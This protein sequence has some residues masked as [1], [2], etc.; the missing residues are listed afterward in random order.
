[1]L[2][3]YPKACDLL[4]FLAFLSPDDLFFELFRT[5]NDYITTAHTRWILA[6]TSSASVQEVL[7][8][9]L[10]ILRLYSLLLCRGEQ[11]SYSMHKLV[12]AWSFERSD[13]TSR[14]KF[15]KIALEFLR[16]SGVIV[17]QEPERAAR[18]VPHIMAC[19]ARAREVYA[20]IDMDKVGIV[21]GLK[22]LADFLSISG[23]SNWG[24][25]LYSFV[26]G[27]YRR[28]RCADEYQY[29]ASAADLGD[30]MRSGGRCEEAVELLRPAL[31]EYREVHGPDDRSV[32]ALS[33]ARTLGCAL[34]K[35]GKVTEAEPLLRQVLDEYETFEG[36]LTTMRFLA[37]LL[38]RTNRFKEAE[39][40]SELAFDGLKELSGPTAHDT[41]YA[42]LDYAKV[43]QVSGQ[44]EKSNALTRHALCD[45]K[46]TF[47]PHNFYTMAC[48]AQT[49]ATSRL[50]GDFNRANALL[51][52]ALFGLE[53]TVG[54]GS[55]YTLS[56]VLELARCLRAQ[57]FYSDALALFERASDGYA[58]ALDSD[59]LEYLHSSSEEAGLRSFLQ[60]RAALCEVLEQASTRFDEFL[61]R[62]QHLRRSF[63]A[64]G[65]ALTYPGGS[66]GISRQEND[67]G[68]QE[69]SDGS[70]ESDLKTTSGSVKNLTMDTIG[71][72]PV[73]RRR[74]I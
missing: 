57:A 64:R 5:D 38:T 7:D 26:H 1:M 14:A 48:M 67:L 22:R 20:E 13:I 29:Y 6:G 41:L 52:E 31:A 55:P 45:Y 46:D 66:S 74:S 10:A 34:E 11:S 73:V 54:T 2:D 17:K 59:P 28:T 16:V 4:M 51:E 18:L 35:L 44:Y 25:E 63:S 30:I 37:L 61:R 72:V 60:R 32:V 65:R 58:A 19:F 53:R 40:L 8:S 71:R 49:G 9:S 62:G 50:L 39:E 42:L 70:K 24:Y 36:A 68:Q 21:R 23:Q 47:G 3:R 12:H 27:H 15:C 43:L 69:K 56:C 33:I